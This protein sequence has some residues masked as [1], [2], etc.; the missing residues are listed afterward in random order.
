MMNYPMWFVLCLFLTEV[1]FY[2]VTKLKGAAFWTASIIITAFG[3]YVESDYCSFIETFSRL[4]WSVNSAC[5]V[6]GFM[7]VGYKLQPVLSAAAKKYGSA[8]WK[9]LAI[10]V[11]LM[12]VM[13]PL[14]L[15]NGKVS[16]GSKILNNGF[17][18]YATGCLGALS[19]VALSHSIKR[20]SFLQ[21]CGKNSFSIMA[22]HVLFKYILFPKNGKLEELLSYDNS[23]ILNSLLPFAIVFSASL[24]IAYL[25]SKVKSRIISTKKC[26]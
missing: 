6:I 26:R 14:A 4:P 10:A 19:V 2:F 20:S 18:L 13:I 23:S 17:L 24:A 1:M 3:W 12:A 5:F 25:Y 16:I 9:T 7:A 22:V 11:A 21:F 15:L 8:R